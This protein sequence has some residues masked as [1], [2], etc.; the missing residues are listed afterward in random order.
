MD[1]AKV[2][3]ESRLCNTQK[4]VFCNRNGRP[5]GLFKVVEWFLLQR[6]QL[7]ADLVVND[8]CSLFCKIES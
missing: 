6:M 5:S 2:Q 7:P 8:V 4:R 3:R 1:G